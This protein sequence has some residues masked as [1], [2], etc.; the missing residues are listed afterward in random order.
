MLV[1][2]VANELVNTLSDRVIEKKDGTLG[3]RLGNVETRQFSKLW[4]TSKQRLRP[5]NLATS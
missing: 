3:D 4:Y 5:K 2:L 1:Y